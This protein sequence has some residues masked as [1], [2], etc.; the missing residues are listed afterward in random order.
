MYKAVNK[1]A[2][3]NWWIKKQKFWLHIL[4]IASIP[5]YLFSPLLDHW[6]GNESYARPHTHIHVSENGFA[7]QLHHFEAAADGHDEHAEHE[8]L[9]FCVLDLNAFFAIALI[10][11]GLTNCLVQKN[12]LT[13]GLPL[14]YLQIETIFLSFLDPPPRI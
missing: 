8:E 1:S 2:V 3:S 5:V 4:L 14:P 6:L 10:N 9:F 12:I 13:S 11:T 7:A